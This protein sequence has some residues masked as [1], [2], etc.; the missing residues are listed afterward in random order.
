MDGPRRHDL[1]REV[2]FLSST[3]DRSVFNELPS[4]DA[5]SE[6]GCCVGGYVRNKVMRL[7]HGNRRRAR[8]W[9]C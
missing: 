7:S 9:R 4:R 3:T 5:Q 8:R 6:H 1:G 2:A